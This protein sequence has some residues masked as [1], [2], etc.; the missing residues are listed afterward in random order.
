M[1]RHIGDRDHRLV[2]S[3][4]VAKQGQLQLSVICTLAFGWLT[5]SPG[6]DVV[7]VRVLGP[8][9]VTGR[10]GPLPLGSPKQRTVLALLLS[11]SGSVVAADVLVDELWVD[12][13]VPLSARANLRAY[14]AGLRRLLQSV[15]P[16]TTLARRGTGYVLTVDTTTF[17]LHRFRHLV[18]AGRTA[19]AKGDFGEAADHL[20]Q[21]LRL[22]RG[23][24]LVDVPLGPALSAWR[25]AIDEERLAAM[26]DL[27][28]AMLRLGHPDQSVRQ[29]RELLGVAPLRERGHA[30]L[31]QALYQSGDVA[32]ALA[33][34][35]AARRCLVD[36]LGIEP[37]EELRRLQVAIL[38]RRLP[39][40]RPS[41]KTV[42]ENLVDLPVPRQLPADVPAFVGRVDHLLRLDALLSNALPEDGRARPAAVVISA[43]AGT[44]G[45]GKT[46]LA[47][48]WAHQV[49]HRFPDGQ[50]YVN[51]RGF[52]PSGAAM[53]PSEV[54]RALLEAFDVAPQRIPAT[55]EGQVGLYRSVLSG[56]RVLILLD[57]ARDA[58]QVR[59]LLPGASGSLVLVTSRTSL[60]G[61]IAGGGA[62]PL[63]VGLLSADEARDMLAGRAGRRRV[64]A[65]PAAAAEIITSC[66]RLPMALAIVAARAAAHPDF[67][68]DAVAAELRQARG[69]LDG[70]EDGDPVT[71]MRAVFSWSYRTLSPPAAQLFQLLG[72]H[73]GPDI[74]AS[75]AA[76]LVGA[77][78]REVR[79]ALVEL[80]H[81]HLL[82]EQTPGRYS[83]HDLL[84]AYAGELAHTGEPESIR[85]A[86]TERVLDHYLH[87]GHAADRLL[88]PDREPI[89]LTAC[90]PS[91]RPEPLVHHREALAW[92]AN[93]YPALL[94]AIHYAAQEG[95]DAYA[96]RLAWIVENFLDWRGHWHE[97]ATTQQIALQAALRLADRAGQ[98]HAHRGIARAYTR[99]GKYEAATTH[100][101]LALALF[102]EL[103]DHAARAA[104]HRSLGVVHM[105]QRHHTESLAHDQR[106]LDL[107][108]AIGDLAGQSLT[109]NNIG[110]HYAQMGEHEQAVSY[111]QQSLEMALKIG[112]R[113]AE[114]RALA[115]LGYA[116]SRL[117]HHPEAVDCCKRAIALFRD[118]GDRTSEAEALI[119]LGGAHK[120]AGELAAAQSAWQ[121][122]LKALDE[123]GHPDAALVRARLSI[124]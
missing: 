34:Y 65:E 36:A 86:A 39:L 56:K 87:T 54:L 60:S 25:T 89:H 45:V 33:S 1:D 59:P 10:A 112:D 108:R 35:D 114:A 12:A 52:D 62:H 20:R 104:T 95:F 105:R 123:L 91:V 122:A 4:V 11:R 92:F 96:W 15:D 38:N 83:F 106:A 28:E 68:L 110:Y 2:R 53:S 115:S 31:M 48:H 119:D 5:R 101:E 50:V 64:A 82:T 79:P 66:A 76:S 51:L 118:L 9:E 77:S 32:G 124:G 14:T 8:L 47:V 90:Q 7:Q 3:K 99:I 98:G 43:I 111:C 61:L 72:S 6:E 17:D 58:E 84:R 94:A 75:V 81:A 22:W 55:L 26:E 78:A 73:P 103:E 93:E 120:T 13:P 63:T 29:A 80:A 44:A 116:H 27:A 16:A 97:L 23:Q 69:G 109:L 49:A 100:L 19:L 30:L 57:N 102:S 67:T 40:I 74:T 41:S 107:H 70:F 46:A 18:T 21:G 113:D 117:D 24:A 85:R 37:G 42:D 121:E 88:R 71:N